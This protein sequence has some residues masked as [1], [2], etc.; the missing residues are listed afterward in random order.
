MLLDNRALGYELAG[1]HAAAAQQFE[2]SLASARQAGNHALVVS[3]RVGQ[4]SIACQQ[5]HGGQ[6]RVL[7]VQAAQAMGDKVPAG[8]PA[9]LR[10]LL[11]LGQA[12]LDAGRVR[13]ADAAATQLLALLDERQLVDMTR[14]AAL[15]LHGEA[16]WE[17]SLA[18]P[19]RTR[20]CV[21]QACI[22]FD[23]CR[24]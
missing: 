16:P 8:N 6:A 21:E 11:V 9:G 14:V 5:A 17:G 4:A 20:A 23:P 1:E 13:T 18:C 10:R 15:C 24:S 12:E 19:D 7:L 2:R 22:R 3:A